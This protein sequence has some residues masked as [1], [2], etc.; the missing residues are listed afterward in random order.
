MFDLRNNEV[1]GQETGYVTPVSNQPPLAPAH[2]L[3]QSH[4][5]QDLQLLADFV[6]NVTV[7]RM[8]LPEFAFK[9]VNI[10]VGEGGGQAA[11]DVE[12]VKGPA[13]LGDGNF[14]EGLD[15]AEAFADFFRAKNNC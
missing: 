10:R 9:G 1:R 6:A 11:H 14:L 2:V 5:A 12:D 13:A 8:E 15:A 3:Q 7:V 4:V